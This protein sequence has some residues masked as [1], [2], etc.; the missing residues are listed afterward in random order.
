V[1]NGLFTVSLDWGSS[2]FTGA[3]RWLQIDV[4]TNNASFP[5]AAL[6]PRVELTPTPYAIYAANAGVAGT[7]S[8]VVMRA[9]SS[10]QLN[11]P[12]APASGQVL[13]YNGT[14]LV[15]TNA[16]K[17]SA[18]WL[19]GGNAGTTAGVNFLG[20]TDFQPLE[21]KVAGLARCAWSPAPMGR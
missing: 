14:S 19:L 9:V 3:R 12:T 17:A 2:V 5:F 10:P 18:S 16:G 4:R 15:W 13:A 8:N 11:T 20:T 7:A 1:T 21:L 6:D